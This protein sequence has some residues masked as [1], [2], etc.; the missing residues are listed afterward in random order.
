MSLHGRLVKVAPGQFE[1]AKGWPW[2][3]RG[4]D[5]LNVKAGVKIRIFLTAP[6]LKRVREPLLLAARELSRQFRGIRGPFNSR[7]KQ[8]Q[9]GNNRVYNPPNR[10]TFFFSWPNHGLAIARRFCHFFASLF[11]RRYLAVLEN[12]CPKED[13]SWDSR[14]SEMKL[15]PGIRDNLAF[16][17]YQKLPL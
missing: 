4:N 12:F 9:G 5:N 1:N 2:I 17:R 3:L 7:N 6:R 15:H 13:R 16:R 8:F 10:V 14:E 11:N